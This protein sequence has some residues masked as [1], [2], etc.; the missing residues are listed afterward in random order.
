MLVAKLAGYGITGQLLKWLASYLEDRELVVK[1]EGAL[2]TP[3]PALSGIP[4]GSHLGPLLFITFINDINN[5][6]T[7]NCLLF[8]M[9]LRSLLRYTPLLIRKISSSPSLTSNYGVLKTLC[10]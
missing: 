10:N 4:Q 1:C 3:F 9:I 6:L 2:S 5:V 7:T 8:A